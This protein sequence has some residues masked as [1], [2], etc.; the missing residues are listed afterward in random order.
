MFGIGGGLS[1]SMIT[2]H[3]DGKRTRRIEKMKDQEEAQSK[4]EALIAE[5]KKAKLVVNSNPSTPEEK[6]DG[7]R[8]KIIVYEVAEKKVE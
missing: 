6:K 3:A 1:V 8:T 7:V 4:L 2:V 5:G